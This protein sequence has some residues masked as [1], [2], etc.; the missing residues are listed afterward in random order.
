[1]QTFEFHLDKKVTSWYRET[2]YV[3][4]ETLQQAQK[5]MIDKFADGNTDDTFNYQEEIDDTWE[6]LTPQENDNQPTREL[7]CEDSSMLLIDN[8]VNQPMI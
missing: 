1:M 6:E 7:W 8:I 2:H 5:I 3:D 4:A